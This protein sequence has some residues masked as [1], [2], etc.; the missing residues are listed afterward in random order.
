MVSKKILLFAF[1]LVLLILLFS[2]CTPSENAIVF[3]IATN[4]SD[5]NPG[6][7][8]KPFATLGK[9]QTAARKLLEGELESDIVVLLHEGIYNLPKKFTFEAK[10]SGKNGYSVIYRN[11]EGHNPVIRGIEGSEDLSGTAAV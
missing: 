3:H 2:G 8:D 11:F 4:G 1:S 6:T 9:A 10:D 7:E 5:D